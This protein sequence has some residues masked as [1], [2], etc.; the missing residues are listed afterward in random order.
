MKTTGLLLLFLCC[1]SL[2]SAQEIDQT[3]DQYQDI[4]F[5]AHDIAH[6]MMMQNQSIKLLHDQIEHN[7]YEYFRQHPPSDINAYAEN[8]DYTLPVVVHII[9]QNG[10]EN[11]A[12]AT[13]IQGIQDLNDA[14]ANVGYYN[15]NTGVDTKIQFCL[16]TR[17]PD[18]GPTT[19]INRVEDPL[20]EMIMETQDLDVKDLIRWEPTSYINIWLVREI[21]SNGAGCGVAGY[22]YFPSVH[23]L[24]QDGIV[25]EAQFFGSSQGASSVQVHEM[26][27]YLGL[28]HTFQGGC[29]NND[30]L[31]QGDRVC[32]TPPDQ[33]T[34]AVPCGGSANSC[35]TDTDSG[36]ATDQ[37][38]LFE[39]YMDYGNFNCYS[40]FTQGQAD[41]MAWH[42]DGLRFSLLESA[43]CTEPC[44]SSL[45]ADFDFTAGII[46]V[47]D[48]VDFIN[49]SFN[50][51]TAEWTVDG[52]SFSNDI[53]ANYQFG[54]EGL[55]EVCLTV[56]NDD[57]NCYETI[58]KNVNITCPVI[59]FF[60]ASNPAPFAGETVTFNNISA[61][62]SDFTWTV[63]GNVLANTQNFEYTI[64][65]AGIFEICMSADNGLCVEEFC[66]VIFTASTNPDDCI[67]STFVRIWGDPDEDDEGMT[68]IP[69]GDGFLYLGGK[70]GSRTLIAKIDAEGMPIWQRT[71]QFSDK[72]DIISQLYLDSDNNIVGCGYGEDGTTSFQPYVFKYDP[73]AN[74]VIWVQ[75]YSNESRAFNIMEPFPG[76]DYIV[77]LDMRNSPSPGA[78]E[79]AILKE[80]DR[81]TG[82]LT[83]NL[84]SSYN[85]GSSETFSNTIVYNNELYSTGRYTNGAGTINMRQS[86]SKFD[87][88]GN[89]I[90]TRFA[91]I[92]PNGFARLYGRDLLIENDEI[93]TTS[94]GDDDG[95]SATVTNFFL[96]KHTLDG[97]AIWTK[98]YEIDQFQNEWA[99]EVVSVP[100][101]FLM[102]GYERQSPGELFV[103]KTDKDGIPLWAKRLGSNG[104]EGLRFT[105]ESQ[106]LVVG[107]F[108]F[109]TAW[110]ENYSNSRDLMLIKMD[111]DG[112]LEDDCILVSDIT[113]DVIDVNN[114]V[115]NDLFSL[116]EYPNPQQ[117]FNA[118]ATPMDANL[119]ITDI[120]ECVCVPEI[121]CDSTFV[122]I[123]GENQDNEEAYS[124]VSLPAS[125]GGGFI[126]GGNRNES[127]L[128]SRIDGAGNLVWSRTLNAIPTGD[129]YIWEMI[130]DSDNNLLAV[131][132]TDLEG[133]NSTNAFAFKYDIGADN[134]VWLNELNLSVPTREMYYSIQEKSPGGNYLI[135]GQITP[136]LNNCDAL[137]VELDRTSGVQ[138]FQTDLDFGS[139]ET[140]SDIIVASNNAV[141]GTGR[142]NYEGGGSARM[143]PGLT[144]FDL[145]G[146]QIWSKWYLEP[147]SN[148]NDARLYPNEIVEDNGLV[149]L[150]RGDTDGTSNTDNIL[151]LF[152]VDYDGNLIWANELD[153]AGASSE[154]PRK[155]ISVSDGYLLSGFYTANDQEGFLIKTDKLG[156]VLWS[157]NFSSP[158]SNE[159]FWDMVV[160]GGQIFLTGTIDGQSIGGPK[161]FFLVNINADGE[162]DPENNCTLFSEL[163]VDGSP[164]IN[165]FELEEDLAAEFDVYPWFVEINNLDDPEIPLF[166]ECQNSCL[167]SCDILPEAEILNITAECDQSLLLAS[168]EICN[169]GNSDL[170]LGTPL[171][172]YNGDPTTSVANAVGTF[173][174]QMDIPAGNCITVDLNI[175]G[176]PNTIYAAVVNDNGSTPTPFSLDDISGAVEEC[177]Y[178]NNI[179]FF[180]VEHT[181]TPLDLGPDTTVCQFGVVDLDAGPGY[182]IYDWSDGSNEQTLTIWLPGTYSVTVTDVCGVTQSDTI[183]IAVDSTTVLDLGPDVT[184]CLGESYDFDV[185]GFESYE[186]LPTDA[187][188]CSDCPNPTATPTATTT[189]TLVATALDGC[190]GVDSIQITV[191]PTT[192]VTIDT[193]ICEGDSIEIFGQSI[194]DA[195]IYTETFTG[196]NGCDSMHTVILTVLETF[197]TSEDLSIC[198]GETVNIFGNNTGIAG[199]YEMTFEA[200]NGCD[201]THIIT[202][203]VRDTFATEEMLS[204]CQGQTADIFGNPIGTAG[205]YEMT[206]EAANGCDSTHTITLEVRDTFATEEMLSICQGETVDIFGTSTG[207]AGVYEMTFEA[208]NGCDSTHTITLEVRDTFATSEEL[209][210]CFGEVIDIF[211]TPT[212]QSGVYSMTFTA[213]N[214]CDSTHTIML[215]VNPEITIDLDITDVSCFGGADGGIVVNPSGG[216]GGFTFIWE[217]GTVGPIRTGLSPGIYMVTTTDGNGCAVE[218]TVGIDQPTEITLQLI[219]N[220]VTCEELGNARANAFGG[221]GDITFEWSTNETGAQI[222]NLVAGTYSVTATDE[223]GCEV[224]STFDITGT[225]APT[226]DITIDAVPTPDDPMGGALTA[227]INGGTGPYDILWNSGQEEASISGLAGG[228]YI[229]EV[230]D[231][232]GCIALDTVNL[233]IGGCIGD[234]IW[235]D[236]NRDGCQDGG[237]PG[238]EQVEIMLTGTDIFGDPVNANTTT[239]VLGNYSFDDLPPGDYQ[240]SI[241]VPMDFLV[242]DQ[243][244]CGN[245]QV[246]NNFDAD[247]IAL[248]TLPEGECLTTIDG[249]LYDAC[250]NIT[251]PGQICCDQVL[252][253]PGNDPAPITPT[254]PA[255]GASNIEYMW[256]FSTE[257]GPFGNGTWQPIPN[258]NTASYDPGPIQETTSFVRCTRAVGCDTW[259]E[260]NPVTVKVSDDAVAEIL[261]FDESICVGDLVTFE[262][263]SNGPGATYSWEFG[264][265]A[266]PSTA[267][268]QQVTVSWSESG[269][270]S[271]SLTVE[272]NNCVSHQE[273]QIAVS[274]DPN[275]CSTPSQPDFGNS[276]IRIET[277]T[278]NPVFNLFPNPVS[279]KF[280]L[281]WKNTPTGLLKIQVQNLNGQSLLYQEVDQSVG[282]HEMSLANYPAGLYMLHI[283]MGDGNLKVLKV[284]KQ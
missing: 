98:K 247:G 242:S 4:G 18:G 187:L 230:T 148:L 94:S 124:M 183:T 228:Q 102:L 13:V 86:L 259:F 147:V 245:N 123:Y 231:A 173:S 215:E 161:D 100:D 115:S 283:Q 67:E 2:L 144:R 184:L 203:E 275:Y 101:G 238:F 206:F 35:T 255:T 268:T 95:S 116:T 168:I 219:L 212:N 157:R 24:P 189:Y 244:A 44:L 234:R 79:D 103:V 11:I 39:D 281:T 136:G 264:G 252:C 227:N 192:E 109:L 91:H 254:A 205:V 178:L 199:V 282:Q 272:A 125:I 235:E 284:V 89:E 5:C 146:N 15:P 122:Y 142:F 233:F 154:R 211:G 74:D 151:F 23:G 30:C 76:S 90:W 14:F 40:M 269:F 163:A 21:C 88:N 43:G 153:I 33:S 20:T 208:A 48:Q 181:V 158:G 51:T 46:N 260:T 55:Y 25:M 253:G 72:Q 237:E 218:N 29:A 97:D 73:L 113:V 17:A 12:D 85:I 174:L 166:F 49:T 256:M 180:E 87:L 19:G 47:G 120:E 139:C 279:S 117:S 171:T 75:T 16:A 280:S 202:L 37:N 127:I 175:P 273:I 162:L 239:D 138:I 152:K 248:V 38:D 28:Y 156:N 8:A 210:I 160:K 149:I 179:G 42:I 56:G 221:T 266:S 45:S 257:G 213:A 249:G 77:T 165:P 251:N 170:P 62:A 31:I 258:T 66:Q 241:Q 111:G 261:P 64:P 200:A 271:I 141:Y 223:N 68:I 262:A 196:Q 7:A 186:W 135:G 61:N 10:A 278:Q 143:R 185:P 250:L 22:A 164:Y 59:P 195:G 209:F 137:L 131:G 126:I 27:H 60:I 121:G 229:V 169:N 145:N 274:D 6:Q 58:C 220:D 71:F 32:D 128:F 99:E 159:E 129:G 83:G 132:R 36:F 177:D 236:Y 182:E 57:Q 119:L 224:S 197:E 78:F 65:S 277:D 82:V 133:D 226:V 52:T 201:S 191:L 188:T 198:A 167:D 41:R 265:T 107:S 110:T 81:N 1:F 92:T 270:P 194:T 232:N 130:L 108:I 54:A 204:I 105:C 9:H 190:I 96:H 155:L 222:L 118:T 26:G 207:T 50:T 34:A 112:N 80:L 3:A 140:Y 104:A 176:T 243:M 114:P 70:V 63:N 172:F 246:D 263:L 93:I 53:N 214:G 225:L 267:S 217:D 106:M 69:S 276:E 134:L 240:I 150:G 193:S 84:N 216:A